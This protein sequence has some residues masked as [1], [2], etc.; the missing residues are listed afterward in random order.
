M[1][2]KVTKLNYVV[3]NIKFI[4]IYILK[5]KLYKL[6][7]DDDKYWTVSITPSTVP[8]SY[9]TLGVSLNSKK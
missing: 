5:G 8:P 1:W 6:K 2:E 9:C 4:N 7:Y 3:Y